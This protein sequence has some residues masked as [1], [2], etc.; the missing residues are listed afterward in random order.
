MDWSGPAPCPHFRPRQGR[1]RSSRWCRPAC[2]P[3]GSCRLSCPHRITGQIPLGSIVAATLQGF[4]L[5]NQVPADRLDLRRI[6]DVVDAEDDVLCA[7]V[8]ELAEAID[9]LGRRLAG[10][11]DALECRALDLVRV[12]SDFLAMLAK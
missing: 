4:Q 3:A 7:G 10:E 5:G 9:D 6:V 12:A 11:I 8:G 2:P 1:C